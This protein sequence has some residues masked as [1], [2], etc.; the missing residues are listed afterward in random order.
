MKQHTPGPW[1]IVEREQDT[2]RIVGPDGQ[3]DVAILGTGAHT[4]EEEEANARLIAAAPDMLEALKYIVAWKPKDW[5]PETARDM[6]TAAISKA[7]GRMP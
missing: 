4:T 3:A 2:P 5:N 7:E 6:A 1:E